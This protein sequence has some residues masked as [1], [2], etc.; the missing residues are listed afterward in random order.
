MHTGASSLTHFQALRGFEA[1]CVCVCVCPTLFL[2][3]SF[4]RPSV[5]TR[6]PLPLAF[7]ATLLRGTFPPRR[8]GVPRLPSPASFA[9]SFRLSFASFHPRS[10]RPRGSDEFHKRHGRSRDSAQDSTRLS[11]VER[12]LAKLFT[13][14]RESSSSPCRAPSPSDFQFSS[15]STR[16][17][18]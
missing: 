3:F 15:F 9:L 18:F 7:F 12:A 4:P 11:T 5:G 14:S 17:A 1:V 10:P 8:S 6:P 13:A 16:V 2:S